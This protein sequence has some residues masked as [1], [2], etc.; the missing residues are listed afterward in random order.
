MVYTIQVPPEM[1]RVL[2]AVAEAEGKTLD[3]VA[4]EALAERA[5]RAASAESPPRALRDLSFMRADPAD[6]EAI[7]QVHEEYD[8]IDEEIWR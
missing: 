3:E 4:L 6:I 5:E 1:H 7:R 8:R 2:R